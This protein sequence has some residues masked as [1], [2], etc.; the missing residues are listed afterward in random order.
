[1]NGLRCFGELVSFECSV[2][3]APISFVACQRGSVYIP[4]TVIVTLSSFIQH[5][6]M[7]KAKLDVFHQHEPVYESEH[8]SYT[9]SDHFLAI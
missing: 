5:L 1:M 4:Y 8:P 3:A 2:I 9:S 7:R 6:L